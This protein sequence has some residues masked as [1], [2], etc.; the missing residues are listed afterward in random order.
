MNVTK[1][2]IDTARSNFLVW[3]SENAPAK[4]PRGLLLVSTQ[5]IYAED[6]PGLEKMAEMSPTGK[7]G[8]RISCVDELLAQSILHDLSA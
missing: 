1:A 6:S 8:L 2:A 3:Q 5:P 4:G 7:F